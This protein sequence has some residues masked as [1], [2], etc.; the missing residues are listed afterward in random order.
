MLM[1]TR[2]S[3]LPRYVDHSTCSLEAKVLEAEAG[4]QVTSGTTAYVFRA[5]RALFA[6]EFWMFPARANFLIVTAVKLF[7]HKTKK[8]DS[9]SDCRVMQLDYCFTQ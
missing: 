5:L 4:G 1:Y 9:Q 6:D 7:V 2:R 8:Y 3:W